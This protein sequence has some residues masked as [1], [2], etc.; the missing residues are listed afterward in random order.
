MTHAERRSVRSRFDFVACCEVRVEEKS[1][2]QRLNDEPILN[3]S[4]DAHQPAVPVL[5]NARTMSLF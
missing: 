2:G 3:L 5:H 1:P 4:S